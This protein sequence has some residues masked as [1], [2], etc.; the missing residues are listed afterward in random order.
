MEK[1]RFYLNHIQKVIHVIS[2]IILI[3]IVTIVSLQITFRFFIGSPFVWAEQLEMFLLLWFV[4]LKASSILHENGHIRVDYFVNIFLR[5]RKKIFLEIVTNLTIL[6]FLL[7]LSVQTVRLMQLQAGR[8]TATIPIPISC[9][10]L[11]VLISAILMI[12]FL[13]IRCIEIFTTLG[14]E[15]NTEQK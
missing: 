6:L 13:G 9:F 10:S 14:R 1:S 5:G 2:V 11:S 15:E 3:A 12:I 7:F 4:Y 8:Y